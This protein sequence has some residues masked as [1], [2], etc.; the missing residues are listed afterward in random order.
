MC[1]FCLFFFFL[2]IS[3]SPLSGYIVGLQFHICFKSNM[4]FWLCVMSQ[5]EISEGISCL[6]RD[7][8][9]ALYSVSCF[10]SM[11]VMPNNTAYDGKLIILGSWE[12][13]VVRTTSYLS[14][15]GSY[16][17]QASNIAQV[18]FLQPY[19]TWLKEQFFKYLKKHVWIASFLG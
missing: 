2:I 6:G 16:C 4:I 19:L 9:E 7:H 15:V 11:I 8:E 14:L 1:L 10:L 13:T 18:D 17:F 12:D 5:R 3:D